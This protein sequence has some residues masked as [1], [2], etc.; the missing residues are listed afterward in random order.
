M[1]PQGYA[2]SLNL[3][4][5]SVQ[6]IVLSNLSNVNF[7]PAIMNANYEL[8]DQKVGVPY[9]VPSEI[10]SNTCDFCLLYCWPLSFVSYCLSLC[11]GGGSNVVPCEHCLIN[12]L[13]I[14]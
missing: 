1:S 13:R 2:A 11:Y 8:Y 12:E 10:T 14:R 7:N 6:Y 3:D 9:R 5:K 4:G